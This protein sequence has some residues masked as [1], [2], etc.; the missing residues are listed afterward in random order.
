MI[1]Q[2]NM[3][4]LLG[5]MLAACLLASSVT[6]AVMTGLNNR[7]QFQLLGSVCQGILKENPDLEQ[8]LFPV[9]KRI[10][11]QP[12]LGEEDNVLLAYGYRESDFLNIRIR[13][14]SC[15]GGLWHWGAAAFYRFLVLA[16]KGGHAHKRADRIP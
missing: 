12:A 13:H 9:L 11:N 15:N 6:A 8:T 5:V 3:G 1:G 14:P 4:I 10:K 16:Q 7:T 2:K